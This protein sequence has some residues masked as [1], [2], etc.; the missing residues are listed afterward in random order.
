MKGPDVNARYANNTTP[1]ILAA[2]NGHSLVVE[3]GETTQTPKV[4]EEYYKTS[5][6]VVSCSFAYFRFG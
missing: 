1:L 6:S 3:V 5:C 4:N 2:I